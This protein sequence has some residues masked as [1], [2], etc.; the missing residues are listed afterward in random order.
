MGA[1]FSKLF[2]GYAARRDLKMRASLR[3]TETEDTS[4]GII[5]SMFSFPKREQQSEPLLYLRCDAA[6]F[7]AHF[8]RVDS[9][10]YQSEYELLAKGLDKFSSDTLRKIN[11]LREAPEQHTALN[12]Y[13]E[14]R[15]KNPSEEYVRDLIQLS[16]HL[17]KRMEGSHEAVYVLGRYEG[18]CPMG[19]DG[20][21]PEERYSQ[22]AALIDATQVISDLIACL[23]IS[24]SAIEHVKLLGR[25][26][27][28]P[29]I[30]D[31]KLVSLILRS[32]QDDRERIIRI[33]R[34]RSVADADTITDLM[35]GGG[36]CALADGAL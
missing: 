18:L 11:G 2:K 1:L 5:G 30:A 17:S 7:L 34:E 27:F 12:V 31:R 26:D 32:P 35:N 20:S 16:E 3:D 9:K 13:R 14:V 19:T 4:P 28:S 8:C 23:E 22:Q 21:Y 36:H 15:E 25:R 6:I 33:M 29:R 10:D 24:S